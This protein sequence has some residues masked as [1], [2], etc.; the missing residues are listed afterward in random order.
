[1]LSILYK[2][3]WL[4]TAS[5][6]TVVSFFMQSC[7]FLHVIDVSFHWIIMYVMCLFSYKIPYFLWYVTSLV[8]I[9]FIIIVHMYG[10]MNSNLF[11]KC[12]ASTLILHIHIHSGMSNLYSA[13]IM[14]HLLLILSLYIWIL[15]FCFCVTFSKMFILY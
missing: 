10:Y 5:L 12:I 4:L 6:H 11:G 15:N 8:I 3:L 2:K 1:M 14:K 13:V 9:A 7:H